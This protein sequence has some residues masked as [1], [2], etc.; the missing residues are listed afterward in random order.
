MCY[1]PV[2][3]AVKNW[4]ITYSFLFVQRPASPAMQR[5]TFLVWH[6]FVVQVDLL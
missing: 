4:N 6:K 5:R 3:R 2:N 1:Y